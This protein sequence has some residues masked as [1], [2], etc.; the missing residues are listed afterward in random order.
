MNRKTSLAGLS[1]LITVA[2]ALAAVGPTFAGSPGEAGMLS[3]RMGIGA[4]EAGMGESGVAASRGA[5]AVFWNPANNVFAE[6]STEIILQHHRYFGL[7]NH[8]SAALAHK[9]GKGVLGFSFTGFYSDAIDRYSEEPV[10]VPEGS[11]KPYDLAFGVSYAHPL[12]SQFGAGI[13]AKFL[14]ERIDLYSDSG[15]A[16]DVFLTHKAMVDG[17]TFAASVTNLGGQMNLK[18]EPFDLPTAIRLGVAFAPAAGLFQEKLTLSGDVLFPK[19]TNEKAHLGAEYRLLPEFALRLGYR[20]NYDLQGLTAGAGFQVGVL[21][22][23]YAYEDSLEGFEDGHKFS[24][25]L[26]W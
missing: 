3:L 13:T 26:V 23:D 1:L 11:F 21:R 22:V 17:L 5:A 8:E 20:V 25:N 15:L 16:F 19:D 10:G 6:F 12:G 18:D 24:L 7:F 4:R 2:W 9:I 14:Y